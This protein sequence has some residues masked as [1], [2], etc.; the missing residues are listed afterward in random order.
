MASCAEIKIQRRGC[1]AATPWAG[2][3]PITGGQAG[4]AYDKIAMM[5]L[6]EMLRVLKAP[7]KD[8][9]GKLQKPSLFLA[10]ESNLAAVGRI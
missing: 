10:A 4:A 6:R 2:A 5:N 9:D 3:H 1:V 7:T 8:Y